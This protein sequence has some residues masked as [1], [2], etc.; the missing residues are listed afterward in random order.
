MTDQSHLDAGVRYLTIC[1]RASEEAVKLVRT[2][3]PEVWPDTTICCFL[4]Y[5]NMTVPV[6]ACFDLIFDDFDPTNHVNTAICVQAVT[7]EFARPF[8][9]ISQG[10]K[11]ITLLDFPQGLPEIVDKIPVVEGWH[12]LDRLFILCNSEDYESVRLNR[13]DHHQR[14]RELYERRKKSGHDDDA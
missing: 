13:E 1:G 9:E 11:T 8:D 12:A 3:L 4:D 10:W 6:G 2:G 5:A 7:Q 14:F